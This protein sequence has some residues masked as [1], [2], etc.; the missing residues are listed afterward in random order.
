MVSLLTVPALTSAA[1]TPAST[2]LQAAAK[3][4]G[5]EGGCSGAGCIAEVIGRAINI[6]LGFLGIVLLC[7][8]LYAGFLWMTAGGDEEKV[9]TAKKFLTNAVIG[10]F[11]IGAAYALTGF[12]LDSL[13]RVTSP[14]EEAGPAAECVETPDAPC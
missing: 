11:I 9:K 8:F 7:L 6:V 3:G 1:L 10:Y 12:V 5:L 14:A 13:A 2:G 4:S